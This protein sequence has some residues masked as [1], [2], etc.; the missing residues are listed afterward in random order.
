MLCNACSSAYSAACWRAH[1]GTWVRCRLS[2][3]SDV[4]LDMLTA[5]R[6]LDLSFNDDLSLAPWYGDDASV[7][8]GMSTLRVLGLRRSQGN[9]PEKCW[10]SIDMQAVGDIHRI[11]RDAGRPAIDTVC[12]AYHPG[13]RIE[14]ICELDQHTYFLDTVVNLDG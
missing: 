6:V 9:K 10:N 14:D 12:H 13:N 7:I 1:N 11:C 8:A 2:D 5:L 3:W 4:P